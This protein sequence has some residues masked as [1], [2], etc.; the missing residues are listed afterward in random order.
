M[1]Q[2]PGVHSGRICRSILLLAVFQLAGCSSPQERAKSYYEHGLQLLAAHD[3]KGAELEFRNAVKYDSKLM[4]AWQ[5][6]AKVDESLH[7]WSGLIPALRGVL[8]LNPSDLAAR[9]KLGQLLL[10]GGAVEDALRVVNDATVAEN[11]SPDLL[12]LK[13][14]ILFKLKDTEGA[15]R[16]A[17][18]AL[19]VD[20]ENVGALIVLASD[21]LDQDDPAGALRIL[22]NPAIAKR[23]DIGIQLF[24]L[25]IFEKMQDLQQAETLLQRL[26]QLYPKQVAFKKE[27]IKLYLA[28]HRNDDAEQEQRAI[29]A[30]D[31]KNTLDQLDL[32]RLLA[33]TKGQAAA[34]Q[35]LLS[36]INAGGDVFPYQIALAQLQFTEGKTAEAIA[37][38]KGLI[39]NAS[40]SPDHV[41]TAQ[42]NLAQIY[43]NNKQIKEADAIVSD[44]LTKDGRN[45][46]GL[47]LRAAIRMDRGE[48]EGAISDL[49]QALND[50]PQATDLML[51]LALAYERS[52]SIDLADR[53]FA[54]AMKVSN[55]NPQVS[56]DYVAF[57]RRRG[58]LARAEDVLT[59]LATRWP[60]SIEVLSALAQVRLARQEWVGAE[61]V[62][63]IIKHVDPNHTVADEVLGA[64]LAG[65]SKFDESIT[66]LQDAYAA[67]PTA[68]QPMYGLVV[69]YLRAQQPAKAVAFLQSVLKANPANAE[70][71]VLLGSVQMTNKQPDQAQQSFMMAIQKQPKDVTG[72]RALADFY[73]VQNKYDLAMKVIK[74]GLEQQPDN[75]ALQLA[76]A[77]VDERSG[78]YDSAISEY[79][80]LLRQDP[81]SIIVANNLASLLADHRTDKASLDQAEALSASLQQTP[82]PQ[83]K[84][85]LGW[86]EYREGDYKAALPL[87]EAAAEALPTSGLVHYHLGMTYAALNQPGNASKQFNIALGTSP[88]HELEGTIRA[89]LAKVSTQ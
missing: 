69:T 25:Q 49:R 57:L 83:F 44:I 88:D 31:P 79:E 16:E 15:V 46:G 13:A 51:M 22:D 68:V 50:Q 3:D 33:I 20:P 36:L 53:E 1:T 7:N 62:A 10:V 61:R 40:T 11:R 89:V 74:A 37:L 67:S 78:D 77:G 32:V 82:V 35:Q 17:Q 42:V 52:G 4:P 58:N 43:L 66:A 63:E 55:F 19:K 47:K 18:A 86:V 59:D 24:K 87:L 80:S 45:T 14:A 54:D 26:I 72:Y 28:Q 38:L 12:A 81:G 73:I 60:K 2:F 85:T 39:G 34:Q 23:T 5:S 6:L 30:A 21:R 65:R 84:D 9:V 76:A 71:Y 48:L 70:A 64:A 29:V 27:L 75:L 8:E 41:L 56:L